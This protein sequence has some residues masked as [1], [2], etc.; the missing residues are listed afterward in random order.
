MNRAS[1]RPPPAEIFSRLREKTPAPK[2]ELAYRT[3]FELL[4]AV[5]LSAQATDKSVNQATPA[6]FR[7]ANT[8]AAML[9]LGE[10]G[11]R[12]HIRTIGL[13]NTKAR[14]ILDT[15][16]RLVKHHG[17]TV[18]RDRDA[19]EALPGV[20]RKT[21]NVVLNNAFGEPTI[22]VDTHIFRVANRTGLAPGKTPRQ[23]EEQLLRVV[24]DEYK[25]DAHHWLILHGR[26]TCTARKPQ[27][28]TCVIADLCHYLPDGLLGVCRT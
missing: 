4:V 22:A 18:P 6:L 3:P 12:D 2:S 25:K 10:E 15:C 9:D 24:P 17:G 27:C 7:R 21:A 19:L 28:D 8:P 13:Y 5:I 20:G 1:S 23:V 26:Y 16:E 11:L 14:N